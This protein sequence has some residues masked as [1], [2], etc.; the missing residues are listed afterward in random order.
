MSVLP[1][2]ET[3]V[4]AAGVGAGGGLVLADAL[5]WGLGVV[6]F[7][8]DKGA[9][10]AQ[11]AINAVP[12]P[13]GALILLGITFLG[14]VFGGYKAPPSNH[15]GNNATGEPMDDAT[16]GHE[17]LLQDLVDEVDHAASTDSHVAGH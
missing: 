3:K 15:A 2:V 7:G 9:G 4:W 16:A 17:P 6:A 1:T 5:K 12:S 14:A 13:L 11:D 8:A 10:S